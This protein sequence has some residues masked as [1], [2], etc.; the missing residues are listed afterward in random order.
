MGIRYRGR[1]WQWHLFRPLR[2]RDY[3]AFWVGPFKIVVRD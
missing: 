2:G 3:W 1:P